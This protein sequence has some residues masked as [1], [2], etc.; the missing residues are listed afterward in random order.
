MTCR[1]RKRT[2]RSQPLIEYRDDPMDANLAGQ[3]PI[4]AYVAGAEDYLALMKPRIMSLAVFTALVGFLSAVAMQLRGEQT[5][6]GRAARRRHG[7]GLRSDRRRRRRVQ[8]HRGA[9]GGARRGRLS[10]P[11][12]PGAGRAREHRG[13]N[14]L[15]RPVSGIGRL[16]RGPHIVRPPG[17]QPS[18]LSGLPL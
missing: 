18:A 17:A 16:P 1:S 14:R 8:L 3:R 9:F 11:R 7:R 12:G 15:P 5:G 2:R 6:A 13:G 4:A 10:R